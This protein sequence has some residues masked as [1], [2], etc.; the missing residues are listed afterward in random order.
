[1]GKPEFKKA[2]GASVRNRR[3]QLGLSQEA[4]AERA[5]LHRTYVCDVERGVRNLSLQSIEKLA[6][7][8]ETSVASLFP[9]A[10]AM[11]E[12]HEG[13]APNV[14]NLSI[15]L[16]E[17]NQDDAA[18]TLQA[19]KKARFA[20]QVHVVGDGAEALEYLFCQGAYAHRNPA[21]GPSVILLDLNLPKLNGMEVLRRIRA[22]KQ[23]K[24]IPVIILTVSQK[25]ADITECQRLGAVT[26][27]VKP[28]DFQ[29][30]SH[31][32]PQLKL[33]WALL[34]PAETKLPPLQ[35]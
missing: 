29:K 8:L 30:L 34:K 35:A 14:A 19:F 17:D 13:I 23:T 25:D 28:V 5:E 32:T 15:L 24:D 21:E 18:M 3:H 27:I 20:N 4:L 11:G 7:A 6:H 26:Y 33:D 31:A 10:A 12:S 1:M 16:V 9:E 2:F 22:E